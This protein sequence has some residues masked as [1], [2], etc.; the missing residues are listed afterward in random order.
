MLRQD[1]VCLARVHDLHQ[2]VRGAVCADSVCAH[3]PAQLD[4]QPVRVCVLLLRVWSSFSGTGHRTPVLAQ[5]LDLTQTPLH[6]PSSSCPPLFQHVEEPVA[7]DGVAVD[8][9]AFCRAADGLVFNEF[10]GGTGSADVGEIVCGQL[11]P[12]DKAM[13]ASSARTSSSEEDARSA[14]KEDRLLTKRCI[15][16]WKKQITEKHFSDNETAQTVNFTWVPDSDIVFFFSENKPVS[17]RST[18]LMLH[19]DFSVLMTGRGALRCKKNAESRDVLRERLKRRS[20]RK[21]NKHPL[22]G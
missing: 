4:E 15:E 19:C 10:S 5:A 18:P 16:Q 13:A 6:A 12:T 17:R 21:D 9:G 3:Q 7:D 8:F 1:G 14:D 11:G 2:R 22:N 20:R